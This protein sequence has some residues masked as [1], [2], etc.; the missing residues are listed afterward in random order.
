MEKLPSEP[1]QI[2]DDTN[3]R[4]HHRPEK[5]KIEKQKGNDFLTVMHYLINNNVCFVSKLQEEIGMEEK[6][7]MEL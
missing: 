4:Y 5:G 3:D 2:N 1:N 7:M 6:Q